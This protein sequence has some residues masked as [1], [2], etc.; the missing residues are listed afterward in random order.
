M[1]LLLCALFLSI[2]VLL[3]VSVGVNYAYCFESECL[4]LL[5][6]KFAK[7]IGLAYAD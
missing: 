5:T 2:L 6:K 7:H 1:K 3:L 4:L